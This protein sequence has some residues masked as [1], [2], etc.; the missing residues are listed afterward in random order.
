[1]KHTILVT[2]VGAIIGYGIIESLRKSKYSLKI[3]GIDI[4]EHAYGKFLVDTFYKGVLANSEEYLD[5]INNIIEKE[6]I[7]LIIPG[8]EQDLYALHRLKD[9]IKCKVVMNSDLNIELSKSKLATFEYFRGNSNIRLIPTIFN[10]DF[11]DC[12]VKLGNPFLL[13]PISSYASK[14]IEKIHT[15]KE[16]IFFTDRIENKCVYQK[17]IGTIDNEFTISVFGD[18]NG[19]YFDS[20]ILKRYLSQEGAT[21]RARIIE[22]ESISTYVSEIV[23]LL[24]PLGPTNIQLRT[25]AGL[26]YLLEINP[27][28]SS[29]CSLRTSFNYNEPEMCISFYL[30]NEPLSIKNKKR[31]TATRFISD[32]IEYE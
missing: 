17:I 28:I 12:V 30:T 20:I 13:K 31:G 10:G 3:V 29:A 4:Y 8:I 21:S 5:F 24:K 16:F 23:M 27:R 1:M 9:K 2:G 11:E 7:D 18:G 25:E 32:H 19:G 14:G 26:P 6:K 15:L 22:D